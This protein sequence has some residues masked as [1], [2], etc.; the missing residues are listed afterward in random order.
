MDNAD[1]WLLKELTGLTFEPYRALLP[2]V[3]ESMSEL[4]RIESRFVE[5]LTDSL[6][7]RQAVAL[8]LLART[9]QLRVLQQ[10]SWVD[11]G[12]TGSAGFPRPHPGASFPSRV[13]AET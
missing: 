10:N 3:S 8:G 12:E 13:G 11:S 2:Q 4:R 9:Y 7:K 5:K 6:T 1:T